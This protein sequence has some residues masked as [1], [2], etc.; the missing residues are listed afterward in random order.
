MPQMLQKMMVDQGLSINI[1]QRTA[2][3]YSFYDHIHFIDFGNKTTHKVADPMNST[4]VRT[5]LSKHWDM[6]ILE[7]VGNCITHPMNY[8]DSALIF[9]DS[10]IKSNAGQTVL[11]ESYAPFKF[12]ARYSSPPWTDLIDK[13]QNDLMNLLNNINKK[14]AADSLLAYLHTKRYS[15]SFTHSGDE[16][17]E[18]KMDADKNVA[19]LHSGVVRAGYAY[20]LCKIHYPNIPLYQSATDTHPSPQ[21]SYLIACLLYKCITKNDVKGACYPATFDAKEAQQI[22]SL[23]ASILSE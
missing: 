16:Y 3:G 21:A 11:F 2:S 13:G 12:P 17:L 9:L 15:D 1:E 5:I 10:V 23:V 22:R 18:I 19:L 8:E 14:Y 7:P 20:E 4:T 6:V